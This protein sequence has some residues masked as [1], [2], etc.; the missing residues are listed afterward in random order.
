MAV[1]SASVATM[2]APRILVV[3]DDQ[4][5]RETL[6]LLLDELH[7]PVLETVDE[8]STLTALRDSPTS[9]VVVL[10]LL[11]PRV[12]DGQRVL[13]AICADAQLASRH[14]VI[15]ITASPRR[16]TP[17]MRTLLASLGAPLILK[18]F[19]IDELL[20]AVRGALRRVAP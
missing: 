14:A 13:H 9:L 18:P 15:A 20:D 10:D 6:H 16:I 8:P 11:L 19:D 17:D 7:T 5:N 12:S 2:R 1:C 4:D 3:D